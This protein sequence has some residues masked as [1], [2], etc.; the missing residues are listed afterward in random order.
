[1]NRIAQSA[2]ALLISTGLALGGF[3][4]GLGDSGMTV[5]GGGIGCCR[6]AI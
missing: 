2:V 4:S 6:D 3:A 1:M 5:K